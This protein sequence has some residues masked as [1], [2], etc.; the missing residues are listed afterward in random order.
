MKK[1]VPN[2]GWGKSIALASALAALCA[3]SV[4]SEAVSRPA[5]DHYVSPSG[6]DS[7][8]GSLSAPWR[9]ANHAFNVREVTPG[10][11]VCFRGGIYP[12]T[13]TPANCPKLNCYMQT[14]N[15]SGIPGSLI[16]FANYP[17]EAAIIQGN[18]RVNGAYVTFRGTPGA[19]PGLVFEGPTGMRLNVIDVMNTHDVTFDHIEVRNSDYHAGFYQYNGYNIR[20]L[21]SYIHDNGR[22]GKINVDNGIYWDKTAGGGNLIANCLI[23]H[24]VS[25][26]IQ[27]YS[28]GSSA[29]P[30]DVTVEG[31]TVV[32]NG[33]Y[34]ITLWGDSNRVVNNIFSN[35]GGLASNPQ[36]KFQTGSN[37]TIDSNVYWSSEP[38]RR[39]FVSKLPPPP[40]KQPTNSILSPRSTFPVRSTLPELNRGRS[41]A[42]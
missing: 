18:T 4:V 11:V 3:L 36:A 42:P 24:N 22:P 1:S 40:A 19:A 27:L 17:G 9:T 26:G 37:Q 31:N 15:S 10:S 41:P 12:N 28:S 39:G 34:G 35:N 6:S 25:S 30:S 16:T 13:V 32:D 20:L 21:N 23:K 5:C 2:N 33:N 29:T 7:N 14:L 38:S 8:S